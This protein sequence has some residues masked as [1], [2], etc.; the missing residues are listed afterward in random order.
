VASKRKAE[1]FFGIDWALKKISEYWGCK[2]LSRT[3]N[4][5]GF[6]VCSRD[7][8]IFSSSSNSHWQLLPGAGV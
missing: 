6:E 2:K 3:R 7:E 5:E 1:E 8:E 4:A